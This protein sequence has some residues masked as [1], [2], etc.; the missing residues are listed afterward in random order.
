MREALSKKKIK[1]TRASVNIVNE[2][3][4]TIEIHKI[5]KFSSFHD[6]K[7]EKDGIRM[8]KAFGIGPGKFIISNNIYVSHQQS[9]ELET[10]SNE[11]FFA[12]LGLRELKQNDGEASSN[13][14]L[15]CSEPGCMA[16][17]DKFSD[18]QVHLDVG[19]Y[20]SD[21]RSNETTYDTL[22]RMWAEKLSS[23]EES[24]VIS[25]S[26]KV[27]KSSGEKHSLQNEGWP[28]AK[29]RKGS[30]RFEE[31]VRAYL[32][33]KFDVGEITGNK[34]DPEQVSIYMRNARDE[35]NVRLFEQEC[36]LTKLQIQ[37]FFSRLAA[38]CRRHQF[39]ATES[40]VSENKDETID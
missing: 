9:T 25:S 4:K 2:A 36:W 24:H 35:N 21:C 5:N 31:H 30:V 13:G 10:P 12:F 26:N 32:T 38:T 1:G 18:L 39:S 15:E 34:S 22:Q 23:V 29:E 20:S 6:F 7:T 19:V 8:W 37:G 3:K 16:I 33:A 27:A 17:F 11:V 40:N 28:L 14:V